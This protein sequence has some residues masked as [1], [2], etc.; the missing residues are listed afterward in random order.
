MT[1]GELNSL[2]DASA[3][4]SIDV[5]GIGTA[6]EVAGW[7]SSRCSCDTSGSGGPASGAGSHGSLFLSPSGDESAAAACSMVAEATN[8]VMSVASVASDPSP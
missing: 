5:F 7:G 3:A 1:R 8:G 6:S 2:G 4:D